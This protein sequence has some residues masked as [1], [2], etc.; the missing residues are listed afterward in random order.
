MNPLETSAFIIV[1]GARGG[2]RRGGERGSKAKLFGRNDVERRK[3]IN[4]TRALFERFTF[5]K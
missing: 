2:G 3:M 5:M 1:C 4:T